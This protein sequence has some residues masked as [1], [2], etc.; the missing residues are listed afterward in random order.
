[1]HNRAHES[2]DRRRQYRI[3]DECIFIGM[4][5]PPPPY[6][7]LRSYPWMYSPSY[8]NGSS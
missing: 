2:P 5:V 1:M 6:M 8:S 7:Y 4:T 3:R